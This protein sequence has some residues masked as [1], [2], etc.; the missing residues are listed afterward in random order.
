MGGLQSRPARLCTVSADLLPGKIATKARKCLNKSLLGTVD[1]R[2]VVRAFD[3]VRR[4]A[5]TSFA[6]RGCQPPGEAKLSNFAES[7]GLTYG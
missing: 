2:R 6:D 1:R 5:N 4:A 3:S 7:S